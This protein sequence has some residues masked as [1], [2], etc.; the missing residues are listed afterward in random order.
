MVV[1]PVTPPVPGAPV[2]NPDGSTTWSG[3]GGRPS[4][5]RGAIQAAYEAA[6]ASTSRLGLPDGDEIALRAGGSVQRFARGLIYASPATGAHVVSGEVER[7][8][9]ARGWEG[10][11]LGYP[12]SGEIRL[13]ADGVVQRFQGGLVYSSPAAGTHEVRGAFGDLYARKGWEGGSL[14]YPTSDEIAVR[15]GV[16]QR[17]QGGLTYWT[18]A[19][20]A[21]EVKG[22]I[23][24]LYASRGWEGGSLGFP[25]SEEVPLRDGGVVQRYLGGLVYW[26]PATGPQ[27]VQG[28]VLARYA[29]LGWENSALGYPVGAEFAVRGG[30]RQEFQ[31]GRLTV[32]PATG[33]VLPG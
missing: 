14:G 26:T 21:H 4:V 22:A 3:V 9:A 1:P 8:Y 33:R 32:D 11:A 15:G 16:V 30:V 31:R 24:Q 6:G 18:A 19:T 23:G 12:T 25:T 27:A 7:L 13:R 2:R 28:A 20:G 17:F 29:A 5:V 10:S